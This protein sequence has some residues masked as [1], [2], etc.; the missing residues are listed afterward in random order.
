MCV[1]FDNPPVKAYGLSSPIGPHFFNRNS[2]KD[3]ENVVLPKAMEGVKM[4]SAAAEVEESEGKEAEQVGW[5]FKDT[6]TN[7]KVFHEGFT[8]SRGNH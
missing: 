2:G 6:P 7:P 8:W 4:D 1:T 3:V 5:S